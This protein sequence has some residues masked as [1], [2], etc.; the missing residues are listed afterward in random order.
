M[1]EFVD[2]F[3]YLSMLCLRGVGVLAGVLLAAWLVPKF[4]RLIYELQQKQELHQ[5]KLQAAAVA[6]EQQ[7]AEVARYVLD[8]GVIRARPN[9]LVI[10]REMLAETVAGQMRLVLAQIE[11]QRAPDAVPTTIHYAPHYARV[12]A[13]AA[14]AI[15]A[16]DDA[17]G[18]A[19]V[20]PPD[21]WSL[22]HTGALPASGFLMGFDLDDRHPVTA[23]WR[24]LYSAL[25]GGQS[26]SGKSTLVR[27]IL[28]Q[29]ALQGGR[30][31][32]IDP[33]AG[34][35]DES[36]AESLQPLRRL[37]LCEPASSDDQIRDALAYVTSVGRARLAGKDTD[38]SPLILVVD[39][40]TGLLTRG[41]VADE[42]LAALGLIAQ[43]TRKVG[44]YALAIGQQFSSQTMQ[45]SV[46][47][48]FVSFL[49]CRAR[50]DVA[51]VQSGS[52][53]FGKL[54]EGMTTGQA[55][56]MTPQGE[57]ECVAVPNTTQHHL[58]LVAEKIN[59]VW[60]AD[61]PADGGA[62]RSLPQNAPD[63]AANGGAGSDADSEDGSE[64]YTS[65]TLI[66]DDVRA[67][68]VRAAIRS[69]MGKSEIL[70]DVWSVDMRKGGR[71]VAQASQE[72][73]EIVRALLG[74]AA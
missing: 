20:A 19:S 4:A 58:E 24:K 39:E 25:I 27:S 48:S 52:N 74:S 33:H 59:G 23:D 22:Y 56:W 12:D 68:R 6:L 53:E 32:V 1:N 36:L 15:E 60:R 69:G 5:V 55:V 8:H 72:Y 43:E 34:S 50:R 40:L 11:A 70:R 42:L 29:S 46:R 62:T 65:T 47:N 26:G 49:S 3:G 61:R 9:E 16:H 18:V 14:A 35:G 28:A 10:P 63:T 66:V 54:A 51:R 73:D 13:P 45:T 30:F 37:M 17:P 41:H 64:D 44:V 67:T 57:I 71:R 2:T 7:R 21:F 38:R 31:V